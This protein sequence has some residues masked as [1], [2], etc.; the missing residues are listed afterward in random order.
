MDSENKER[1]LSGVCDR[2]NI[3]QKNTHFLYNTC[4][5]LCFSFF[6]TQQKRNKC[7]NNYSYKH[8]GGFNRF[9]IFSKCFRLLK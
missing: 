3:N 6:F 8:L 9:L 2:Q 7:M 4:L 5:L 1:V